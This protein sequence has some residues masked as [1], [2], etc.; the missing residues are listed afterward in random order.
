[1]YEYILVV[2]YLYA[3]ATATKRRTGN[4]RRGG[5]GRSGL[6]EQQTRRPVRER[7]LSDETKRRRTPCLGLVMQGTRACTGYWDPGAGHSRH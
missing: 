6:K 7:E 3:V 1:M 5:G 4:E 2:D